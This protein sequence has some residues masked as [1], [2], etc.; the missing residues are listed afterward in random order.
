MIGKPIAL[1][2]VPNQRLFSIKAAAIYLGKH[3]NTIRKLVD[4]G[5]LKARTE[6]DTSGRQRRTFTLENLDAYI[7]ALP[8]W[9]DPVSGKEPGARKEDANGHL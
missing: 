2:Q 7:D 5:E 6:T 9:Y 4:R 3:E 8:P 1:I